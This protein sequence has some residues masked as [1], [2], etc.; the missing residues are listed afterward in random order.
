V[1]GHAAAQT[2]GITDLTGTPRVWLGGHWYTV[3]GVLAPFGL[4]PEIDHA[5]L[6][7]FPIATDQFGYDGHPTQIYVR[8]QTEGTAQTA[9]LLPRAANP[10]N[11]EQVRVG[12]PS[13]AFAARLA[14]AD[15]AT[16]LYLGLGA[17]ALL[18]G[19]VGIAN[20]MVIS[21]LERR[22]EIGLPEPSAPRGT[23]SPRS[24]SSNRCSLVPPAA[25]PGSSSAP[26]SPTHSPTTTAGRR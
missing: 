26:R 4:A 19:G 9:R 15:S 8:T 18:V 6:I 2:L 25:P 10:A 22:S 21:V 23:T 17:V 14:V 20:V 24:S 16:T 3:I 12:R 5:A 1:L 13:D 7:G 11:P